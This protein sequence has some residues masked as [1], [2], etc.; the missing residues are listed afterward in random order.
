MYNVCSNSSKDSAS[1]PELEHDMIIDLNL[2]SSSEKKLQPCQFKLPRTSVKQYPRKNKYLFQYKMGKT[3]LVDSARMDIWLRSPNSNV[4]CDPYCIYKPIEMSRSGKIMRALSS[5]NSSFRHES[6]GIRKSLNFDSSPSPKRS[7]CDENSI[8]SISDTPLSVLTLSSTDSPDNNVPVTSAE[9]IDENQNKTPQQSRKYIRGSSSRTENASAPTRTAYLMSLLGKERK[10]RTDKS[11]D[12][13]HGVSP[14]CSFTGSKGPS[15]VISASTPRNLT[16]E[17]NQEVDARPHTPVNMINVIPESLSAIK[18]SHKKDKSYCHEEQSSTQRM[19]I[20]VKNDDLLPRTTIESSG[21][22]MTAETSSSTASENE[23][24]K[25]NRNI[26]RTLIYDKRCDTTSDSDDSVRKESTSTKDDSL[27]SGLDQIESDKTQDIDSNDCDESMQASICSTDDNDEKEEDHSNENVCNE[28]V[29]QLSLQR[30]LSGVNLTSD[31]RMASPESNPSKSQN[32]GKVVTPENDVNL[33]KH[34]LTE[35]IKKSHKKVKHGNRRT[36]FKTKDLDQKVELTKS[37]TSLE[38]I[39]DIDQD[40]ERQTADAIRPVPSPRNS[41]VDRPST[42]ENVN[43]SRLLLLD[44]NSVK[45]SHKKDKHS[46]RTF[47][48][49][50]RRVYRKRRNDSLRRS[51]YE[52]E[53]IGR[54]LRE[55]LE[56]KESPGTMPLKKRQ[57]SVPE[58]NVPERMFLQSS[59]PKTLS[60]FMPLACENVNDFKIFT[61]IKKQRPVTNSAD[62]TSLEDD[63]SAQAASKEID[64]FRCETPVARGFRGGLR[65]NEDPASERDNVER[66]GTDVSPQAT[67]AANPKDKNEGRS[68]PIN[69]STTELLCNIDSIKKSHKKD[70]HSLSRRPILKKKRRSYI[71]DESGHV[72]FASDERMLEGPATSSLKHRGDNCCA[73]E[74]MCGTMREKEKDKSYKEAAYDDSQPSTSREADNMENA[75]NTTKSKFLTATPPNSLRAMNLIKLQYTTSIK[76]SHKKERDINAQTKYILM[77]QEHELSDDGSIFDEEDRANSIE[78]DNNAETI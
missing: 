68:T 27:E 48:F 59:T 22:G 42:P 14:L 2:M 24:Q 43:S 64:C 45:K 13:H 20:F 4:D 74:E 50:E 5:T 76:K 8:S 3:C 19:D 11:I 9:S 35:S 73:D 1:S 12:E 51:R 41:E 28:E 29:S 47:T 17:F 26:K 38:G 56:S 21:I 77:S 32:A 55:S 66:S 62:E 23:S 44:F 40:A 31:N 6:V 60:A 63:E 71:V 69:M 36:L 46:K 49:I 58:R 75:Q 53:N 34:V 70:K 78:N 25:K 33:L 10:K 67:D 39:C 16:Q 72:S 30:E 54:S 18:K 7:S 52:E 15:R 65:K 57:K 61:P 37:E